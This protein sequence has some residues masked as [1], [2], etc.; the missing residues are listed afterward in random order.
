MRKLLTK[1][2][3]LSR[4]SPAASLVAGVALLL[5]LLSAELFGQTGPP[6]IKVDPSFAERPVATNEQ[7]ELL[8]NR[9]LQESEG[10]L[11]ILIGVTD[12]SSL[13]IPVGL[14]LRYNAKLWPLPV[15]ESQVTVY[16]VSKNDDW[17]EVARFTLRVGK[18]DANTIR[19]EA[20]LNEWDLSAR[21]SGPHISSLGENLP[22]YQ[23]APQPPS[24]N[25]KPPANNNWKVRFMPSLTL[26]APSQPAQSTFPGPRPERAEFIDLNIQSSMKNEITYGAFSAQSAFDFAGSSF[27]REALR[28]GTLGGAA[29]KVDLAGY[30]IHL[31][32]SKVKFDAGHFSYGAQRHLING[33]SSR[34]LQITVPFLNRFDF[35]AAAMNG[36]Q[37]VGYDNFF[38]LDNRR[39]QLLSGTLGVELLPQ[40]PGGLRVEV[41]G[42]NAYFQAMGGVNRGVVTDLQR[43]NG[44]S[45]RLIANDKSRRFHFEGGFTRSLFG[46]P[47]DSTLNQGASVTLLPS[48]TRNAHYL[49]A[50]YEVLR[51][52]SLT[53]TKKANL[54][55]AF[56][57]ENVAPLF[58]SLGA[59]TQADKVQYEFSANGSIN[60]I[61]AQFSYANFH[62]N[63]RSIPSIL[64]SLTGNTH[65][66]LAAAA[67]A[68][69]NRTESSSWLPRLG[70]SFDR[71]HAL[72]VAIPATGGFALDPSTA[73]NL[74]GVN[75]NFSADWQVKKFT[76]G[77]NVNRSF[78]DNRQKGRERA[79][80]GVL[81]HTGRLGVA[82][83]GKLNFNIDLSAESSSN[84]ESGRLDRI[85][86]IGPGLSW[87]L[88]RQMGL[89]LNL[90]NNIAG[91]TAKTSRGRNTEFDASWTY[92]FERSREGLGKVTG[93]F[94][95]RYA[96]QYSRF[97]DR[98]LGADIL[99]KN[100][101][102]T[103]NLGIT[104]F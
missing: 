20:D 96:N 39:N 11:A 75:Q 54:S 8:L 85:Y 78:Q 77:Y 52:Y 38:G 6:E 53:M 21:T 74:V 73:P 44:A 7:I 25:G 68:L 49:E 40:S 14:R 89:T 1:K 22:G 83:T 61:T 27:R 17:T 80:L 104:F 66:G 97:L 81:V 47:G 92:R 90:A 86:R 26:T 88:S 29:P 45:V 64:R 41:S 19:N 55:I 60:E 33:F 59:A 95:V 51:N 58:R 72:G 57:E 101:T 9:R 24:T 31:Q 50:S 79:D 71:A 69:L 37:L 46:S 98:L 13:F 43:S 100:Q 28:F 15:G 16:L 23:G 103:A 35:S 4:F 12:V 36:I 102:L 10:R 18:D 32:I 84:R 3:S 5:I 93:Q 87:Q 67:G 70:Y 56:R 82:A 65:I 91:D 42:L 30:Q 94:F 48:L 99:R 62:D 63:L 34:G 76:W 2:I